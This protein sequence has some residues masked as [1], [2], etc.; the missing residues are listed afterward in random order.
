MLAMKHVILVNNVLDV[1]GRM[2][3]AFRIF[4]Q[5][6]GEYGLFMYSIFETITPIAGVE[7]FFVT[8]VTT[9]G[10][11]WWRIAGIATVANVVGAII[12]YFFLA[13]GDNRFYNR[14]LKKEQQRR[15]ERLFDTYGPWAIFIFAMTPLPFFIIIFTAAIAKM[16]FKQY[17][18]AVFFSRGIRFFITTFIIHQFSTVNTLM[19]VLILILVAL[20]LSII[21]MVIQKRVLAY[22]EKRVKPDEDDLETIDNP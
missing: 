15:A 6:F 7:F 12:V 21:M 5:E 8:L 16:G 17:I 13:K 1:I 4:W 11:P 20:P 22:F 18:T 3:D 14:L 19:L 9:A 2:Y 10:K